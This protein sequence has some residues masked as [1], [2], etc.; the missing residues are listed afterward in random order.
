MTS[1]SGTHP[2]TWIF[3]MRHAKAVR[4]WVETVPGCDLTSDGRAEAR[5]I[6]G[7][8]ANVIED[9][10]RSGQ[11]VQVTCFVHET[12]KAAAATARGIQTA[13]EQR[14]VAIAAEY[15]DRPPPLARME[16]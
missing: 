1:P 4:P 10:R 14:A 7:T 9:L 13:Y 5:D 8:L 3:I 11:P 16:P 12:T 15:G 6:G 2:P